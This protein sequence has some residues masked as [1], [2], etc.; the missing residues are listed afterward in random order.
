[1]PFDKLLES[2]LDKLAVSHIIKPWHLTCGT[3][4][5]ACR[6]G[7]CHLPRARVFARFLNDLSSKNRLGGN[8]REVDLH[9]CPC[10]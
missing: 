9:R 10:S 6:P 3:L 5:T 2:C 4:P 1:M 8:H 7:F